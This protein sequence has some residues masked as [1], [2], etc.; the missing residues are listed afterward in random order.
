MATTTDIPPRTDSLPPVILPGELAHLLD[1]AGEVKLLDVRTPAEFESAHIPG[2]CNLPLDQLPEQ[3][4]ALHGKVSA[5][6]VLVCRSGARA[7]QAEMLLREADV[8]RV[9]VLEGGLVAWEQAGLRVQRGRAR[10]SLERQVRA[11][12]GAL[13]LIGTLG[14]LL[15]WPPLI[16]LALF[17]GA[18]LLFA[19]VTDTCMT[20]MLLMKL[21]YNRGASCDVEEVVARL[22][23]KPMSG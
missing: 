1:R 15:V 8:P 3:A 19:G 20:V 5:P 18:G 13:V 17:V 4:K 7:R 22:T 6:L 23:T 2:S 16:Y 21:P 11:I 12:A 9:H 10:W 14:S